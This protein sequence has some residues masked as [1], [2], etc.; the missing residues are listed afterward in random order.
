MYE[1]TILCIRRSKPS[2]RQDPRSMNP[3]VGICNI[4]Q[5]PA[6]V[7]IGIW[8]D[9]R[10]QVQF[11]N[12]LYTYSV[13]RSYIYFERTNIN[14]ET[15]VHTLA[16]SSSESGTSTLA[17]F[18]LDACRPILACFVTGD[19]SKSLWSVGG[20]ATDAN[21]RLPIT[22]VLVFKSV[23]DKRLIALDALVP[24]TLTLLAQLLTTEL[25][26]VLMAGIRRWWDF[27]GGGLTPM[28]LTVWMGDCLINC[29][30]EMPFLMRRRFCER[31]KHNQCL[32]P[33]QFIKYC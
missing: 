21:F 6:N 33:D 1:H 16:T 30:S 13:W 10:R 19:D 2:H 9:K 14:C 5:H 23:G 28:I 32:I 31:Q 15:S 26:R 27:L 7:A 17:F 29:R 22:A 25:G 11:N 4:P 8:L 12:T 18:L 3:L 24:V 20:N